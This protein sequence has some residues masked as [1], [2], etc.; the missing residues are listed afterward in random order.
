MG[1]RS[2]VL[3]AACHLPLRRT[4]YSL[5][6]EGQSEGYTSVY[7]YAEHFLQCAGVRTQ[8]DVQNRKKLIKCRTK[9]INLLGSLRAK[10]IY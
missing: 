2:G 5:S 8:D 9:L 4:F 10:F 3:G 1:S 6:R 7:V